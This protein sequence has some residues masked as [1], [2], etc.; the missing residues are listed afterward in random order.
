LICGPP[1]AGKTTLANIVARHAGYNPI[2]V[3]ASD[4]R[5]SNVLRNKI[6]S[7][8]EM[9][10]VWGNGK[11][12]CIILDEIDG[13]MNGGDGKTAI[14]TLQQIISAPL[15][16]S[17]NKHGNQ[18]NQQH[19]LTRPLICICNDQYASVLRPLR[20]LTKIFVLQTP[21]QQRLMSRLKHICRLENLTSTTSALANLCEN[22]EN[23]IRYCLNALQF[24]SRKS[25][26][27]TTASLAGILGQK[28]L[29]KDIYSVMNEVFYQPSK[30]SNASATAAAMINA[31][32]AS[33][34]I[35]C[36]NFSS[37]LQEMKQPQQQSFQK[38]QPSKSDHIY[39]LAYSFGN[40]SLIINGLHENIPKM[41]FNDP[42]M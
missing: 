28:D 20:K 25:T 6:I 8:M 33:Q 40:P 1:G 14:A 38:K 35:Y 10:S 29:S 2:E 7:A 42:T 12:N 37:S 23:D 11:P 3:N 27:V 4:D 18:K 32:K 21:N 26:E 22:G 15:F 30:S 24:C 31:V 5:T 16:K 9:Q 17:K 39:D 41:I 36:G 19:P 13:A 34:S